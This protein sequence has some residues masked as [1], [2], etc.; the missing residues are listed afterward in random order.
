[1]SEQ[2][3][4]TRFFKATLWIN[5][6]EGIIFDSPVLL[7]KW[8]RKYPKAQVEYPKEETQIISIDAAGRSKN[9]AE[10]TDT[11]VPTPRYKSMA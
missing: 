10:A 1:M 11:S 2:K 9:Q 3:R 5:E 7:A 4:T 6:K 8:K